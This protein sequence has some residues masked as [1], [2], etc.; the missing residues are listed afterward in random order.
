MCVLTMAFSPLA[1]TATL[2]QS[3]NAAETPNIVL[4]LVDDLGKEWVSCYGAEDIKTPHIDKLA[5]EGM[6]FE[7]AYSMPQCT[8]SRVSILTGQYPNRHG[9]VNHWDVPRWGARAHFDASKYPSIGKIM[10]SAGYATCAAGKWQIDDFRVEPKAMKDAGFDAWCMWTGAEGGNM[11]ASSKRYW[12]PY[13]F[14]G[15]KSQTFKEKFGPDLYAQFIFDF[16][17]E[18]KAKPFFVYWPMA[19]THTP[20]VHTPLDNDPKMNKLQKHKAMVRYTDHLLGKLRAQ[21]KAQGVAENTL[22]I[23][24]TDNGTVRSITGT[25]LGTKVQGGKTKLTENGI[26]APFIAHWPAKIQKSSVS[27]TLVDFT[28]FLPTFAELAGAEVEQKT[29]DGSS[30]AANLRDPKAANKREWILSLG[31]HP[32]K[33][34]EGRVVPAQTFK[35]RSIRDTRWKVIVD[36]NKAITHLHDLSKDP[37][38]KNN[39]LGSDQPEAK[40][41]YA[42]FLSIVSK[43][44]AVDAHPKY[45]LNPAQK[46][47]KK[48]RSPK[49]RKKAQ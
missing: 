38:E 40:A 3:T 33:M 43:M 45:E 46:W 26:N 6:K 14:K 8:P 18:K 24:T 36:H 29:I 11:E 49:E 16:I 13:I 2:A 15:V 37:F 19:L 20:F 31:S 17:A 28:D 9:W 41:A 25:R 27:H 32:A 7:N 23:F 47:D 21:L 42:K 22:I 10:Q 44:P 12:D 30:F 39:L 34:K 4:I 35:P 5:A 48:A 1:M